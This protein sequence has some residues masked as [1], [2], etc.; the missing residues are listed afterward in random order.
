MSADTEKKIKIGCIADDFTGAGDAASYLAAGGMRPLLLIW[1]CGEAQIPPECDAVVVALKS[2]SESP[3][4]AI[5]ES[6][7]AAEWLKARGAE[8]LYFKY[9]STFD[10]TPAGNIGPVSDAI[11]EK[12]GI[13]YTV[14]CPTM[15]PNGR[16]VR[17]GILYVYGV[18]LAESHMKDHPLNPMW[19]SSVKNLMEAQSRYACFT[20]SPE[21]YI[22]PAG[23]SEYIDELSK[24]NRHFYL[25]PDFFKPE[26][27]VEIAGV[28]GSLPFITGAS[29]LLYYLAGKVRTEVP[30]NKA[31][32]H[33]SAC[34]YGRVMVA[35]SCSDMSRRQIKAWLDSGGRAVRV[36]SDMLYD[37]AEKSIEKITDIFLEHPEK[38]ILVYSAG[39]MNDRPD[40]PQ[41]VE[42]FNAELVYRLLA[43]AKVER[44]IIAGGETS[45]AVMKRLGLH[46]FNIGESVAPGVPVLYPVGKNGLRIVLKS[47]NFGSEDFFLTTLKE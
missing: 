1:P 40:Q 45:G 7:Q 4:A 13:K 37:A 44:L 9:C 21:K 15:I 8:K 27:G 38:D 26:H 29:E 33:A 11:M 42:I 17:D 23:L 41:E 25:V 46:A 35:G 36:G 47:G 16:M 39:D 31:D 19:D 30:E 43:A 32:G 10:S 20:L 34:R 28:F 5:D 22:E 14:L 12:Y 24:E 6:L 18:P 3:E 2:R